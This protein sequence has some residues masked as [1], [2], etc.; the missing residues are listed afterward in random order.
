MDFL[1]ANRFDQRTTADEGSPHAAPDSAPR[2]VDGKEVPIRI[3]NGFRS[4]H[5]RRRADPFPDPLTR[6]RCSRKVPALRPA[7]RWIRLVPMRLALALLVFVF[8]GCAFT[9]PDN[10]PLLTGLSR[11]FDDEPHS[12]TRAAALFLVGTPA[13]VIDIVIAHPI[14]CVDDSF[15]ESCDLV[16]EVWKNPHGGITTKA[17]L[18]LPKVVLTPVVGIGNFLLSW[19]F[20]SCFDLPEHPTHDDDPEPPGKQPPAEQPPREQ[21]PAEPPPP[22]AAH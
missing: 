8:G 18:F 4:G 20:R 9:N 22:A 11:S 13:A 10:M 15:C 16:E 2:P 7:I 19:I 5:T 6:S 17:F 21:P 12:G 14:Q 3:G 1:P